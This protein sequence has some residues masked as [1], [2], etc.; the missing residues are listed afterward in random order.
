MAVEIPELTKYFVSKNTIH[1]SRGELICVQDDIFD[2]VYMVGTGIV[3]SYDIDDTGTERTLSI[4]AASCIFPLFWLMRPPPERQLYY[5]EAFTDVTC[6]FMDKKE[7]TGFMEDHPE[8]LGGVV[9][10]LAK[11]YTHYAD[12]IR[13]LER[14]RIQERLEYVLLMLAMSLGNLQGDVAD[15]DASITQED[16]SKLAGVTRESISL[17]MNEIGFKRLFWKNGRKTYI[18]VGKLRT[19]SAFWRETELS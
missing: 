18:D 8:I 14:S 3:K 9:D 19:D 10:A 2:R 6:Y 11:A 13:S 5:Y 7:A 16:I 17:A 1:F 15:I 4:F 12:R